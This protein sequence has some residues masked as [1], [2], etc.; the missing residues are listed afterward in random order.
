MGVFTQTRLDLWSPDARLTHVSGELS[1]SRAGVGPHSHAKRGL[2]GESCLYYCWTLIPTPCL[3]SLW[4]PRWACTSYQPVVAQ[5]FS[6]GGGGGNAPGVFVAPAFADA[7]L[8]HPSVAQVFL[9]CESAGWTFTD[10]VREVVQ[11]MFS[12]LGQ[13][14]CDE[15]GFKIQRAAEEQACHKGISNRRKWASLIRG[16]AASTRFRFDELPNYRHTPIPVGLKYRDMAALYHAK[17][18]DATPCLKSVIG[19][20]RSTPWHSPSPRNECAGDI[21]LDAWKVL[22]RQGCLIELGKLWQN[23]LLAATKMIVHNSRL[24]G[25]RWF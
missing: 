16:R 13:T 5:I 12:A 18:S 19:P 1:R 17:V 14:N 10:E 6:G 15:N 3:G 20:S 4:A 7:G 24:Y 8:T 9:M 21:D 25:D 23:C 2:Y 11:H 22:E